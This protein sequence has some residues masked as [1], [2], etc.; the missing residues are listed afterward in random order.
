MTNSAHSLRV[1]LLL[2]MVVYSIRAITLSLEGNLR[3]QLNEITH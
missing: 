2:T 1:L 3:R